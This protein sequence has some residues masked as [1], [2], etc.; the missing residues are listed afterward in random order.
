MDILNVNGSEISL[1]KIEKDDFISITDIAKYKSDDPNDV[2]KN[3]LRSKDTIEF[4][5]VWER[6]NNPSFKPVEFDGFK[7]QAGTNSF[8]LSPS[9]WITTTNAKGLIS[10][11]GRYGGTYAHKDIAFEFASWIS[12]EFKLYIIQDYQRLKEKEHDPEQI[13]WNVKRLISKTNY[14]IHTDAI[15]ENLINSNLTNAQKGYTYASEA[16]MLNVA[17]FGFTAKEWKNNNP[18]LKGNQRDYASMEELIVLSNLEARNGELI[19]EGYNQQQRLDALN[20]LARQQMNSLLNSKSLNSDNH[21]K[22]LE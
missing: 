15:K 12:A 13:E 10:K 19:A 17:I 18:E 21:K 22:L 14:S 16:D 8:T 3:W 2:I 4:L 7:K 1:F 20:K 9:K 5:G 6:I 11:P